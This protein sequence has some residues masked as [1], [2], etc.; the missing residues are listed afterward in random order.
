MLHHHLAERAFKR[1]ASTQPFVDH[2]PQGVLVTGCTR[3][4]LDLLRSHI[5]QCAHRL[6]RAQRGTAVRQGGQPKVREQH[7]LL[8]SQQHIL[9]LDI[10]VDE[11][12]LVGILQGSGDLLHAGDDLGKRHDR[13]L[14]IAST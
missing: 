1:A 11:F 8:P 5:G 6:L 13:A 7:L 14:G 4:P 3:V 12:L 2:H 9:R 10:A